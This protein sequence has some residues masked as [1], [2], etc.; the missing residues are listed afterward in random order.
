MPHQ[1]MESPHRSVN[2][3]QKANIIIVYFKG[4]FL[5]SLFSRFIVMIMF[6][7]EHISFT[8]YDLLLFSFFL[9]QI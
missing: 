6:T 3:G 2:D 7:I 4:F 8:G 5:R 1:H 9:F